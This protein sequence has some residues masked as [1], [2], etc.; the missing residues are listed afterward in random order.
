MQPNCEIC[1]LL[2]NKREIEMMIEPISEKHAELGLDGPPHEL[3]VAV[4]RVFQQPLHE[5]RQ[6]KRKATF[7]AMWESVPLQFQRREKAEVEFTLYD[8]SKT[9]EAELPL[10]CVL[11]KAGE[12]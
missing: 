6:L 12:G 3:E 5:V 8:G 4:A 11:S 2:V 1:S 10:F 9:E 7:T